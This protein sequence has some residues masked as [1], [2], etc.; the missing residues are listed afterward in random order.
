MSAADRSAPAFDES[1]E[2][3]PSLDLIRRARAGEEEA[4]DE[5][6]DSTV[7]HRHER[8]EQVRRLLSDGPVHTLEL[9][10]RIYPGVVPKAFS[11]QLVERA[12]RASLE[13]LV[14]EG[15]AEALGEDRW[16]SR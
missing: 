12:T 14:R 9:A 5:L 10:E 16:R 8:I 15:R 4:L 13:Y 7:R 3:D 11:K 1:A 2:P 6:I